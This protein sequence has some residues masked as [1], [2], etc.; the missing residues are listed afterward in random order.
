MNDAIPNSIGKGPV[1]I[2]LPDNPIPRL[3][4]GGP[5]EAG[6]S[7]IVGDRGP[8]HAWEPLHPDDRRLRAPA[9]AERQPSGDA[10][11]PHAL[12][13]R[14]RRPRAGHG[15][16]RRPEPP[17]RPHGHPG[18]WSTAR[19]SPRRSSTTSRTRAHEHDPTPGQPRH[20]HPYEAGP[21]R[22]HLRP[23]RRRGDLRRRRRLGGPRPTAAHARPRVDRHA[24]ADAHHPACGVGN[25][26]SL[27]SACTPPSTATARSSSPGG[28]RTA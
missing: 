25:R 21:A 3:A 28:N 17:R 11:H 20:D 7:Y 22:A 23:H 13:G 24:D 1:S 18:W 4:R 2:D 12:R 27:V 26:R 6:E 5:V 9:G 14:G 16:P 8:R 10:K 19:S 15:R